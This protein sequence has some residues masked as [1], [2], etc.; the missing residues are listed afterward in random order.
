MGRPATQ[1]WVHE[2]SVMQQSVLI[3]AIRG[4][5]G[6][7]KR[8]KHK[9]LVKWYRRCVLLSAF[10]GVALTDPFAPGGGS[11]TGPIA[12]LT[13]WRDAAPHPISE[14]DYRCSLLQR[15]SDDFVDSRDEL[16]AHY[17]T[18]FMHAAEILGYKHPDATVREFWHDF[19]DRL[20]HALHLWPETEAQL[21]LR[22][23]DTF[24]GW[25][26]RNDV[27]TSCSD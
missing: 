19:Y 25:Q 17:T 11:F 10:D 18:H 16:P 8:H 7:P 6:M 15:A 9:P 27:S 3:S 2:I 23:G 20:V 24:E 12:D 21:D 22:L 13:S 4:C 1:D 5:D 26:A 14:Y